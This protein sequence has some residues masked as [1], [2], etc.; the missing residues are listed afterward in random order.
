MHLACKLV[1]ALSLLIASVDGQCNNTRG[2]F[3]SIGNI[4]L[5][6]NVTATSTCGE[7]GVTRF[8]SF[9]DDGSGSGAQ[10]MECLANDYPASNINDNNSD[11]SWRSDTGVTNVTV[12]LDLERPMLLDSLTISWSTPRPGAM[13]IERSHDFGRSWIPYRYYATS[14]VN[15]FMLNSTLITPDTIFPTVDAVCTIMDSSVF[16]LM[17][18]EVVCIVS[19]ALHTSMFVGHI[20][21]IVYNYDLLM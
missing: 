14:C 20:S 9:G 5:H 4:A 17:D 21:Y 3:P 1:A 12:Q 6:R 2:C 16:P 10:P 15:F 8:T 13:I 19:H 11:T 7:D 18:S